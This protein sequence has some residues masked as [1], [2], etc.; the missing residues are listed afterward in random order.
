MSDAT[1]RTT[2]SR[3]TSSTG[4]V[5]HVTLD[6][7]DA[8]VT[9]S[10]YAAAFGLGDRVRFRSA[11][12][13]GT[14]SGFRGFT[15]SLVVAQPSTVDALVGA[16]LDAGAEALKP[17]SKS[18]WGYGGTLRGQDG[19]I[20][21]VATSSRKDTAPATRDVDELV[22]LLGVDD[23]AASKRFYA[24]RGFAVAKSYLGRYVQ[25][26]PAGGG[27]TLALYRRRALAKQAGAS[28]DATAP[29]HLAIASPAGPFTDPD[30]FTWDDAS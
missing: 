2:T 6:V 10:R 5:D 21:Q 7:P 14:G 29:H 30:G 18:L 12:L 26:E 3:T 11:D 13:A 23:V 16:A 28:P 15:L 17:V 24:G 4:Y 27:V 22:L 25:F 20:W 19:A 8:A 1:T 9:E